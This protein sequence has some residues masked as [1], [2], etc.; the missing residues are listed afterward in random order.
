MMPYKL[1]IIIVIKIGT[2][3]VHGMFGKSV[4]ETNSERAPL[5]RQARQTR[6]DHVPLCRAHV[7]KYRSQDECPPYKDNVLHRVGSEYIY[8]SH[9]KNKTMDELIYFKLQS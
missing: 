3:L 6:R 7:T 5:F 1:T 8:V 9:V 4:Q 2:R